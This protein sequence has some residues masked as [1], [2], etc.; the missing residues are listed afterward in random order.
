VS[1]QQWWE[2]AVVYQ[3]YP[4]SFADADGDGIGDLD[5]VTSRVG[6]LK[7]LGVDA[8]WLSPF[9]PSALADGG[10]DVDDYRAVDP[11][12]GDLAAFDRMTQALHAAGIKV[13]VDIVPNHSSN[14]HVWFQA[15]LASPKGSPERAR[16]HFHDGAGPDGDQA[17]T[18]WRGAFGGS[19][20]EQVGD[21]QFYLHTFAPEQADW[22]WDHPEVRADFLETLRFWADRGVD[23]FRV[24]VAVAL[25]KDLS[26][27]LPSREELDRRPAGP[28]HPLYDRDELDA[29]YAGWRAVFD[30]YDPPRFAV[31]EAWLDDRHRLAR[32]ARR[33]SLGAVF[34][35]GLM[36][37]DFDAGAYRSAIAESLALAA[38]HDA[39]LTWVL[40]NHD[41]LRPVTRFGLPPAGGHHAQE[42]RDYVWLRD[43]ARPPADL[44]LGRRRAVAALLLQLA[45]P[46][47]VY[48][49]QG[50]EL[51]LPEVVDLPEAA[52]Q[53]PIFFR[54]DGVGRDGCRVPLP[55]TVAGTSFGFGPGG[56]H[57]PQPE[58]FADYAVEAERADPGS[59]LN[60]VRHALAERRRRLAAPP[61]AGDP[62]TLEWLDAPE[63]VLAFRRPG[64]WR[65]VTNFLDAPATLEDG[66][67]VPGVTTLWL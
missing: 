49:Y 12:L 6:Y 67:A 30:E 64:G 44:D 40:G 46:G 66:T 39:T 37:T 33:D 3:I 8:V 56:A 43:G 28:S 23:G 18:D 61:L 1:T 35:F 9:Y 45:L 22:N 2:Q 41:V 13:I 38:Q 34:D 59:T 7:D 17:P 54:S 55:W 26:D 25:A 27:P 10:Y 29:I 36:R 31:A 58:W 62:L 5:G 65:C 21:G 52:R 14:R 15:A 24:D 32:F 57:L 60:T 4:R 20:W 42:S 51:G 50:E 11:R 48:L 19:A 63:G 47:A 53:D 16:Y